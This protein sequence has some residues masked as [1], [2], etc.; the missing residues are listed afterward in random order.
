MNCK[1]LNCKSKVS[2]IV[3]YCKNCN[4]YF[5]SEHRYI[6]AHSC[7]KLSEIKNKQKEEL[8][9]K[10]HRYAVTKDKIIKI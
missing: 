2:V 4:K 6:E 5:C 9:E 3:G 8:N 1:F 7:E 10:L